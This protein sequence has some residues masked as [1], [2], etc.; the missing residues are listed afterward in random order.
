M[1]MGEKVLHFMSACCWPLHLPS[2]G[3]HL[4]KDC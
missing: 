3:V 1:Q 2:T 4:L